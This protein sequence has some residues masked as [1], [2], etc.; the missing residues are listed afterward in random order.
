MPVFTLPLA[1]TDQQIR[2]I[3]KAW[4][5]L[6]A[7]E[8]HEAALSLIPSASGR[9]TPDRLRRAIEGYGVAEQDEATLALL[10]EEHGVERFVVTSLNDQADFDPIRHIDVDRGDPFDVETG[11][12]FGSV[13]YTDI[14]LN[15]SPSDL[16]AEFDIKRCGLDALTL[17]FLNIHVM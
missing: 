10:L 4:S 7:Q 3:V 9:W 12:S 14:P 2:D 8:D 11:K 6:L 1:A 5:E 13:L 16:T 17:E 15:G